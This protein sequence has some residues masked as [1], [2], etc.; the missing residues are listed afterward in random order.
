MADL[1]LVTLL[2]SRNPVTL[3]F[4]VTLLL[5]VALLYVMRIASLLLLV[6]G[7]VVSLRLLADDDACSCTEPHRHRLENRWFH[8][9]LLQEPRRSQSKLETKA[10]GQFSV[11]L[12]LFSKTLNKNL[13]TAT[14]S[15]S[16]PTA[17]R[18]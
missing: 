6:T 10:K 2:M 11:A 13:T 8:I 7:L 1:L 9:V 12:W 4:I 18:P 15:A 17:R 14:S 5:V 16:R 3:L